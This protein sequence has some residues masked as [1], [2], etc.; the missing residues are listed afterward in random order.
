MRDL[1]EHI[2]KHKYA[3]EALSQEIEFLL[4]RKEHGEAL[5]RA[6]DMD[7]K[8]SYIKGLEDAKFLLSSK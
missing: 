4:K 6:R 7:K 2:N 1:N 5:G 3:L 8:K